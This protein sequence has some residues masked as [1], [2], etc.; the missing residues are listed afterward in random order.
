MERLAVSVSRQLRRRGWEADL[1][2]AAGRGDSDVIRW[3]A[4]QGVD[5]TSDPAVRSVLDPGR[6]WAS[7][8]DLARYLRKRRPTAVNFHYGGA[9]VSLKDVLAARLAGIRRVVVE[10]HLPV[11]WERSGWRKRQLTRLSAALA[12]CVVVHSS[13][14][15]DVVLNA[16]V[17]ASRVELIP[18]GIRS[19]D[20]SPDQAAVRT[21][22]ELPSDAF[23]VGC[24]ARL[25]P[26]KGVSD[27]VRAMARL[28]PS[29]ILLVAG[30]GPERDS[31][32]QL[33]ERE[34]PGRVKFLGAL[35]EGQ[36][37][38]FAALDVFVL[39]SHREGF[40]LVLVEAALQRIPVVGTKIGGVEDAVLDG[41]T[42]LLVS[43]GDPVALAGA[44]SRLGSTPGLAAALTEA[45][46]VRA[47]REFTEDAF[48]ESMERVLGARRAG[49]A[50]SVASVPTR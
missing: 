32:E 19:P 3:A 49:P 38:F 50:L 13:A 17:P 25:V 40:G 24:M 45:G 39:P 31:L 11:S 27:L 21:S 15:R 33:A 2:F 14:V 8:V 30:D 5:A 29:T 43:P 16:G 7:V 41:R 20:S 18:P 36:S 4:E 37:T 44:I 23:V 48:G 34:A 1:V 47:S 6:S 12:S 22:L 35:Q 9:H 42:G 46:F 26:H 10:V 28:G